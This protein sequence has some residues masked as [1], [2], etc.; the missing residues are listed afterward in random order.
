MLLRGEYVTKW[1][2]QKP[3]DMQP[4][5]TRHLQK[6]LTDMSND[7]RAYDWF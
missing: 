6:A 2:P 3:S 7:E 5:R 4:G 1:L